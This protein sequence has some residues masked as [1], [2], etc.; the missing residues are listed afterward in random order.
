MESINRFQGEIAKAQ[1]GVSFDFNIMLREFDTLKGSLG[2]TPE[3]AALEQMLL[4]AAQT[5]TFEF[6]E[7]ARL[8]GLIRAD[9]NVPIMVKVGWDIASFPGLPSPG[10]PAGVKSGESGFKGATQADIDAFLRSNPGD[11]HRIAKAFSNITD[12]DLKKKYGFAS[13]T[14]GRFLDFGAGT[15]VR[16]HGRERVVTESEGRADA[17]RLSAMADELRG[18][19][20]DMSRRD[21]TTTRAIAIAVQD[22]M[23]LAR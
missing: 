13:G 20:A 12:P 21:R 19:R 22:A 2:N 18:L 6:A 17:G 8:F 14:M 7:F 16:L 4:T 15:D 11:E 10:N 23:V 3:I 9:M 5:G 1:R